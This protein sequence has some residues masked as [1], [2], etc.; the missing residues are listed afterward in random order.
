MRYN[1]VV[2]RLLWRIATEKINNSSNHMNDGL[3]KPISHH[4]WL[5]ERHVVQKKVIYSSI[6]INHVVGIWRS[7]L[8]KIREDM[9]K[10]ILR[11]GVNKRVVNTL[12]IEIGNPQLMRMGSD[13]RIIKSC[14]CMF[15]RNALYCPCMNFIYL[16]VSVFELFFYRKAL[17]LGYFFK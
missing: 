15:F 10:K 2:M 9:S 14:N 16:S 6:H 17:N 1:A 12:T 13:I 3:V 5:Y 11:I 7:S 4:D 8:K